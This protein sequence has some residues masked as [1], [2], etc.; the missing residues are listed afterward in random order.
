[1]KKKVKERLAASDKPFAVTHPFVV[2][3]RKGAY[4]ARFSN[5]KCAANT[6][7]QLR[8]S[9]ESP[10]ETLDYVKC[11]ELLDDNGPGL[12]LEV[13]TKQGERFQAWWKGMG[14]LF[15]AESFVLE[16]PQSSENGSVSCPHVRQTF[17]RK[18]L[19]AVTV[20][21]VVGARETIDRVRYG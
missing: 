15:T 19:L 12:W 6:A 18:D 7:Y 4:H 8:G 20:L 5:I 2:L 11:A 3:D 1:M 21:A 16:R 9:I 17:H 14:C 10:Y 13:T